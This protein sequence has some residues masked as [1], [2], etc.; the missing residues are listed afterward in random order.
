MKV[1]SAAIVLAQRQTNDFL[2]SEEKHNLERLGG[3][4]LFETLSQ[5][6]L[7]KISSNL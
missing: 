6:K 3:I 2:S 7:D 5:F 4:S 1:A